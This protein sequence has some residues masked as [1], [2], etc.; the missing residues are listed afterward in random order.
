MFLSACNAFDTA[1]ESCIRLAASKWEKL[2][3]HVDFDKINRQWA[4]NSCRKAVAENETPANQ[5]RLARALLVGEVDEA[6]ERESLKLY[7]ASYNSNYQPA[8]Q[9]LAYLRLWPKHIKR[10]VD[11]AEKLYSEAVEVGLEEM[12]L[13][14]GYSMVLN[15]KSKNSVNFGTSIM[16]GELVK[17]PENYRYI[18]EYHLD[19]KSKYADFLLAEKAYNIAWE[20]GYYDAGLQL[21]TNY[22]SKAEN[23]DKKYTNS[24]KAIEVSKK[25]ANQGYAPAY[26]LLW[27]I[28]YFGKG[29][30]KNRQ[31]AFKWAE[32]GANANCVHCQYAS[33]SMLYNGEGVKKNTLQAERYLK[34]AANQNYQLAIDLLNDG[35]T[36]DA[37][38]LR[39]LPDKSPKNC[40]HQNIS[41]YD[42]NIIQYW[43]SCDETLNVI[44]CKRFVASEVWSFFDGKD[45]ESCNERRVYA[46]KYV[47]NLYGADGNSAFLR[48]AIANTK[49]RIFSCFH[50]LVPVFKNKN[51]ALCEES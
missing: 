36:R 20:A 33:G 35:V 51:E 2:E 6:S 8:I 3:T 32:K 7:Q 23:G 30:M 18:T 37:G 25:L 39:N 44:V 48:K 42:K 47:D 13:L 11:L 40:I 31:T 10:R 41:S 50:P 16:F 17:Y 29:R 43:N 26:N 5:Y 28:H 4:I 12:K 22:V 1:E 34:L 14:H 15:E 45:R 21:A 9:G 24:K 38:I 19:G 27:E 49:V 46:K